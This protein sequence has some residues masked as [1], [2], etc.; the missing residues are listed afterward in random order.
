M[1]RAQASGLGFRVYPKPGACTALARVGARQPPSQKAVRCWLACCTPGLFWAHGWCAA[2]EGLQAARWHCQGPATAVSWSVA[3][4][5]RCADTPPKQRSTVPSRLS[6]CLV[7]PCQCCKCNGL[8]VPF[9]GTWYLV[10]ILH[11]PCPFRPPRAVAGGDL[12]A[13]EGAP[14]AQCYCGKHCKGQL[15]MR[16]QALLAKLVIRTLFA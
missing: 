8:Q 4:S 15:S 10:G 14:D 13:P 11:A 6:V 1:G 7:A 2:L 12:F 3:S 5:Q 9:M 16:W